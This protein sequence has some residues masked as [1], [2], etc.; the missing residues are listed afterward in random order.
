[1]HAVT[2]LRPIALV[3]LAWLPPGGDSAADVERLV[4]GQRFEAIAT[5]AAL[6]APVRTEL[7][8]LMRQDSL[9]MADPGQPFQVTDVVMDRSLPGRRLIL[10]GQA[11]DLVVVHYERGGFAHQYKLVVL[12]V[13]DGAAS[14]AATADTKDALPGLAALQH[15]GRHLH[16]PASPFSY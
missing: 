10:A 16:H 1:M 13:A 7:A 6:P 8:R 9:R 3:V 4:A 12:R 2:V 15:V 14:V 11:K 5:V